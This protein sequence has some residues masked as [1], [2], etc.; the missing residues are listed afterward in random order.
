MK[1]PVACLLT[2]SSASP[3][4]LAPQ[5]L[6]EGSEETG[7]LQKIRRGEILI[8]EGAEESH[9][10]LTKLFESTSQLLRAGSTPAVIK[11]TEDV[12]KDITDAA[13]PAIRDSSDADKKL[14]AASLAAFGPIKSKYESNMKVFGDLRTSETASSVAHKSCR[15][16]ETTECTTFTTCTETLRTDWVDYQAKKSAFHV[17][18]NTITGGICPGPESKPWGT[19]PDG[20]K[21]GAGTCAVTDETTTLD[22]DYKKV[23][24][25]YEWTYRTR[26]EDYTAKG[27]AYFVAKDKYEAQK[28]VCTQEKTD[29]ETKTAECAAKKKELEISSCASKRHHKEWQ[30]VFNETFR[31]AQDN[32]AQNKKNVLSQQADRIIEYS[33]IKSIQCLLGKIHESGGMPC[34]EKNGTADAQ[35]ASCRIIDIDTTEFNLTYPEEPAP[36]A[37]T[38]VAPHACE[39][40]FVTQ[41]YGSM[42]NQQCGVGSE[43]SGQYHELTARS[44]AV[45]KVGD[46]IGQAS[47]YTNTVAAGTWIVQLSKPVCDAS[48]ACNGEVAVS[49]WSTASHS[50]QWCA[51]QCAAHQYCCN[52]PTMS[53]SMISC[54]QACLMRS[55]GVSKTDVKGLCD[56][57][58]AGS[59]G[60]PTCSLDVPTGRP[61]HDDFRNLTYSFCG[62]CTDCATGVQGV[63]NRDEC[64]FGAKVWMLGRTNNQ[65]DVSGNL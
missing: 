15:N 43:P 11:F 58:F 29:L 61:G 41:E 65:T 62:T 2:V 35:I 52:G 27:E 14:L 7:L 22:C 8:T 24:D 18:H 51:K 59:P 54:A 28:G 3:Q 39:A 48:N 33:S 16:Q 36:P 5:E 6:P 30:D 21:L 50:Q 17:I 55:E 42:N 25:K 56:K 34:D 53:S 4:E 40:S 57:T 44:G 47:A 49:E 64:A 10:R 12:L 20:W 13:L 31:M 9:T 19:F 26:I 1:F 60:S 32:L 38:A 46:E 45:S 37:Q 63:K 23:G